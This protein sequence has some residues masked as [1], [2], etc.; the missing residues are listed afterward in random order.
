[1]QSSRQKVRHL[2]QS[3][4]LTRQRIALCSFQSRP[5]RSGSCL[6]PLQARRW[7]CRASL[8][9]AAAAGLANGPKTGLVG[10][11]RCKFAGQHK[12][13]L[14]TP[15]L[16]VACYRFQD[17]ALPGTYYGSTEQSDETVDVIFEMDA[18]KQ[19]VCSKN[20]YLYL[21]VQLKSLPKPLKHLSTDRA[22]TCRQQLAE[23][24]RGS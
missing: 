1:M 11:E 17:G 7:S 19:L 14:S 18:G 22:S 6:V 5:S 16:K 3:T 13:L 9:C 10:P 23:G 12:M 8:V 21:Y 24:C 15:Q 2:L 4:T 20:V